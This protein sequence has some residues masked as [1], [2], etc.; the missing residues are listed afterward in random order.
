[1]P[2]I[3]DLLE[4]PDQVVI[5]TAGSDVHDR[6]ARF[7]QACEMFPEARIEMDEV[8]NIVM[9]PGNCE[10]SGYQSAEALYQLNHWARRDGT[11][12]AFDSST[13]FN[14]PNGAKRSPDAAWV[15]KEVLRAEGPLTRKASKT[16]HVPAFLIE[17]SSPSDTV[18]AQKEKCREWVRNGVQEAILLVPEKQTAYLF[19]PDEDV[20]TIEDA[21]LIESKVLKEFVLDCRPIWEDLA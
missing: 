7:E 4:A 11:G 8:G 6:D 5:I 14:L 13:V 2:D 18:K 15:S 16:R 20:V 21:T 12:R 9:V 1:M 3:L 19:Y 17:V 10:D